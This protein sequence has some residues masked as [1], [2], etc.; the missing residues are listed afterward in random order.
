MLPRIPGRA[1]RPEGERQGGHEQEQEARHGRALFL[2][3]SRD[4]QVLQ[5]TDENILNIVRDE[6]RQILGLPVLPKLD[7]KAPEGNLELRS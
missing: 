5:L 7:E 2:G 4:E 3:G 6:L 1:P